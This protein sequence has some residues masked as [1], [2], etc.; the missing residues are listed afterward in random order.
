MTPNDRAR[1]NHDAQLKNHVSTWAATDP[2]LTEVVNNFAFDEIL[3]ESTLDARMRL[4]VQLSAIIASQGL[5]EY[6]LHELRKRSRERAF[7]L[8]RMALIFPIVLLHTSTLGVTQRKR[9]A[10]DNWGSMLVFADLLF[11]LFFTLLLML[12]EV[13]VLVGAPIAWFVGWVGM[14]G[15]LKREHPDL[16][17]MQVSWNQKLGGRW[18]GEPGVS[19]IYFKTYGVDNNLALA[20]GGAVTTILPFFLSHQIFAVVHTLEKYFGLAPFF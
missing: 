19:W 10:A 11:K 5:G 12:L 8:A 17:L 6:R 2:E 16:P 15:R 18:T 4:M 13:L 3:R 14:A 7:S 9:A 1:Q 20:I